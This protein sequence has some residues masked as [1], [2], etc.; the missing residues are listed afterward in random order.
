LIWTPQ[1]SIADALAELIFVSAG[2]MRGDENV[3]CSLTDRLY[4]VF[5]VTCRKKP[6]KYPHER[7]KN[8]A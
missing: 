7:V 3:L 2:Q 8:K 6:T 5:L 4:S 1:R